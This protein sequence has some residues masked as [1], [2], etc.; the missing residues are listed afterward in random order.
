MLAEHGMRLNLKKTEYLEVEGAD[1]SDGGTLR[2]DGKDLP[3]PDQC[4]YLGSTLSAD[5]GSL[6]AV[7]ARIN[8]AWLKWRECTGVLCDKLMPRRV[9][10]KVYRTV[11][12][13]A[14]LY[15]AETFAATAAVEKKLHLMEMRMLRWSLGYTLLLLDRQRANDVRR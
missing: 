8:A 10:S 5:G 9:K 2:V 4:R 15:E 6:P 13:P 7:T 11:V 14:A 1:G 12:R 3:R